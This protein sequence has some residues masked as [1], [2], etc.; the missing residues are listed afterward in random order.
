VE[1]F[2]QTTN[3]DDGRCSKQKRSFRE[4]EEVEEEKAS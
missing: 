1:I 2:V 3:D 4:R